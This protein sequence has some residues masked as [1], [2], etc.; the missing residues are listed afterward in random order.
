[1]TTE[2]KSSKHTQ[3]YVTLTLRVDDQEEINGAYKLR[4]LVS[5]FWWNTH[6]MEKEIQRNK[7]VFVSINE[8]DLRVRH[9][10]DEM[11]TLTLFN[12]D[13][14]ID[15]YADELK[16]QVNAT[17]EVT[18]QK[19]GFEGVIKSGSIVF[20]NF[21]GTFKDGEW[22]WLSQSKSEGAELLLGR[23]KIQLKIPEKSKL[24][25]YDFV[26]EIPM[27]EG[28]EYLWKLIHCPHENIY[29]PLEL[30]SAYEEELMGLVKT[31][32]DGKS[33]R[34]ERFPQPDMGVYKRKGERKNGEKTEYF[35]ETYLKPALKVH[36][37]Q[38]KP[39]SGN[40]GPPL[41]WV[42]QSL[43]VVEQRDDPDKKSY[44]LLDYDQ[45]EQLLTLGKT[46]NFDHNF[47]VTVQ[48]LP[49]GKRIV[50]LQD[51]EEAYNQLFLTH[52]SNPDVVHGRY[53]WQMARF[54]DVEAEHVWTRYRLEEC[55]NTNEIDENTANLS[56]QTKQL[57]G[58]IL[59]FYDFNRE[60][61]SPDD[62]WKL[63]I[64]IPE[65]TTSTPSVHPRLELSVNEER[66]ALEL[67]RPNILAMTPEMSFYSKSLL[68]SSS[69]PADRLWSEHLKG[70][71]LV[72]QNNLSKSS[73][74]L[75]KQSIQFKVNSDGIPILKPNNEQVVYFKTAPIAG[76]DRVSPSR[77]NLS[78]KA[79][80]ESSTT[81][82]I[83][84]DPNHGLLA[85]EVKELTLLFP[86]RTLLIRAQV[87]LI[88]KHSTEALM[89]WVERKFLEH[90]DEVKLYHRNLVLEHGEFEL[91][92]VYQDKE[93]LQTTYNGSH[94]FIQAVR[95]RYC[96]AADLSVKSP[97]LAN[98]LP[99]G[100]FLTN[101]K[102]ITSKLTY[103][104]EEREKLPKVGIAWEREDGK[105]LLKQNLGIDESDKNW[106][107]YLV[108]PTLVDNK[109]QLHLKEAPSNSPIDVGFYRTVNSHTPLL[110]TGDHIYDNLGVVR[111]NLE[112]EEESDWHVDVI[113]YEPLPEKMCFSISVAN[114][115]LMDHPESVESQ[116]IARD[117]T[118]VIFTCDGLKVKSNGE[119]LKPDKSRDFHESVMNLGVF[120]FYSHIIAP[121][122]TPLEGVNYWPRYRGVPFLVTEVTNFNL[123]K[124]LRPESLFFT[125]ILVNPEQIDN[126][127][128]P[129]SLPDFILHAL[130]NQKVVY[131]RYTF[132][133]DSPKLELL[134]D[135]SIDWQFSF[136]P[137]Q[138]DHPLTGK[139]ICLTGDVRLNQGKVQI[140]NFMQTGRATVDALGKTWDV[141][142]IPLNLRSHTLFSQESSGKYIQVVY[143]FLSE[144]MERSFEQVY[145]GEPTVF[146]KK[147][148][149]RLEV[150][151]VNLEEVSYVL[152]KEGTQKTY[153]I[154]RENLRHYHQTLVFDFPPGFEGTAIA[155]TCILFSTPLTLPES[156]RIIG[157][158]T[159]TREGINTLVVTNY[160]THSETVHDF[161]GSYCQIFQGDKYSTHLISDYEVLSTR[162]IKWEFDPSWGALPQD[163]ETY[164][165]KVF[166]A[167][168]LMISSMPRKR[169]GYHLPIQ[170]DLEKKL[171]RSKENISALISN[172]ARLLLYLVRQEVR[173]KRLTPNMLQG[174]S[175]CFLIQ[176][177]GR[178]EKKS[179]EECLLLW[180]ER[181][182]LAT[183]VIRNIFPQDAYMD[184][185]FADDN[186]TPCEQPFKA[187][188][189]VDYYSPGQ[190]WYR[191][192]TLSLTLK[193]ESYTLRFDD[194]DFSDLNALKPGK[195]LNKTGYFMLSTSENQ[196]QGPVVAKLLKEEE[197]K[198]IISFEGHW[199]SINK[200]RPAQGLVRRPDII[201]LYQDEDE[202]FEEKYVIRQ[203]TPQKKSLPEEKVQH[204][205][206]IKY[207]KKGLQCFIVDSSLVPINFCLEPEALTNT[208]KL[209]KNAP[210]LLHRQM[211]GTMLRIDLGDDLYKR[212]LNDLDDTEK[213][214]I[215]LAKMKGVWLI[216][217]IAVSKSEQLM[218][219][220]DN[221]FLEKTEQSTSTVQT[222]TVLIFNRPINLKDLPYFA[223]SNRTLGKAKSLK[224]KE[225][226][227]RPKEIQK[228]ALEV[229][230][231][232]IIIRRLI[233][234]SGWVSYVFVPSPFYVSENVSST[235]GV[236]KKNTREKVVNYY[237]FRSLLPVVVRRIKE[238]RNYNCYKATRGGSMDPCI[239][240][241]ATDGD[242]DQQKT[243]CCAVEREA[244][245]EYQGNMSEYYP[246]N[247]SQPTFYLYETPAFENMEP[248]WH[249]PRKGQRSTQ[250][251]IKNQTIREEKLLAAYFLPY[252]IYFRYGS[253]K[254]GALFHHEAR[255]II[256]DL[257]K[258][259]EAQCSLGKTV[260]FAIREPQ[261][262]KV[263]GC[264]SAAIENIQYED[265]HESTKFSSRR[266]K[267]RWEDIFGRINIDDL[268]SRYKLALKDSGKL[269]Y[270]PHFTR[271]ESN[272]IHRPFKVIVHHNYD[273]FALQDIEASIPAYFDEATET[274]SWAA[275]YLASRD[276]NLIPDNMP[277]RLELSDPEGASNTNP[278]G[279]Q[280]LLFHF[281]PYF[282]LT[283]IEFNEF[284][285]HSI[286]L[287]SKGDASYLQ[288]LG[289]N[290]KLFISGLQAEMED[291][292]IAPWEIKEIQGTTLYFNHVKKFHGNPDKKLAVVVDLFHLLG[293]KVTKGDFTLWPF[294]LQNFPIVYPYAKFQILWLASANRKI[295]VE[296]EIKIVQQ[297]ASCKFYSVEKQVKLLMPALTAPK[298]AG[299]LHLLP[300]E[301]GEEKT[302]KKTLFFGNGA[303]PKNGSCEIEETKQGDEKHYGVKIYALDS[304]EVEVSFPKQPLTPYLYLI[305]YLLRGQTVY[306]KW[307]K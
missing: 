251:F 223:L 113:H 296:D 260:D 74:P 142:S 94:A 141:Q 2:L 170:L 172:D 298:V 1:M 44:T 17:V 284:G 215:D 70:A 171:P 133:E 231:S 265:Q 269:E 242:G 245:Y 164:S 35:S 18:P 158:G 169:I 100:T 30:L 183:L 130:R 165:F 293:V 259:N 189:D 11:S 283:E 8:N 119:V 105:E 24:Q 241:Q 50:Q 29:S 255:N 232:G 84:R 132:S 3:Q 153:W 7:T 212:D 4:L 102:E 93:A 163:Q 45:I 80:D 247:S 275:Y 261:Q 71:S 146:P 121:S 203:A 82:A 221:A 39:G 205:V 246:L 107:D 196:V 104:P 62:R 33:I 85:W 286:E 219:M 175:Y 207:G 166:E 116:N 106:L 234:S 135:S 34:I 299:V 21:G 49:K 56:V 38:E 199:F 225:E 266:L 201:S 213:T 51:E 72:F 61:A 12:R 178:E 307:K 139:L 191:Y 43:K 198:V 274:S 58:A 187:G 117:V 137:P 55:P 235:L 5:K 229:G 145:E 186:E 86:D 270:T 156:Q 98:W 264:V 16:V 46:L 19:G 305:K 253:D 249:I 278:E 226:D 10:P 120:G 110:F 96:L 14:T 59:K 214:P 288:S 236:E 53:L 250:Q 157:E 233:G 173:T 240:S 303:N 210:Q 258:E 87:E 272:N 181:N 202:K 180:L 81:F 151:G 222:E 64:N 67:Y 36:V 149:L 27:Q 220:S 99:G 244:V 40:Y 267:M 177:L 217:P 69:M 252:K 211:F 147:R 227:P 41:V 192:T 136:S 76:I 290:V 31:I 77:N 190:D 91:G 167:P 174:S 273:V 195:S 179:G 176:G 122:D 224:D 304:E 193:K 57:N 243:C 15:H 127:R 230:A 194:Q 124:E 295:K 37:F 143:D 184:F 185:H 289:G 239:C 95:D 302:L 301:I 271:D 52:V 281:R 208:T 148:E 123:N 134:K 155:L 42:P 101:G 206:A 138:F 125:A 256:H 47:G 23:S 238:I 306:N 237:D 150:A 268:D 280:T 26:A 115:S 20:K 182:A 168:Y 126:T 13:I 97:L 292:Q 92:Q 112:I 32:T 287:K 228:Q 73:M 285:T 297:M 277:E 248:L 25:L 118:Q 78:S 188:F 197:G 140:E 9:L 131:F 48:W 263:K 108:K 294:A 83:E 89:P 262:V 152:L 68:D 114:R 209:K 66:I 218:L 109:F 159:A 282:M 129:E 204:F 162:P 276:P 65:N 144:G 154:S 6:D 88:E 22:E 103:Y 200:V 279:I 216:S 257:S 54:N 63:L 160:T 28:A 291:S 300:E 128:N 60:G 90:Q 79:S 111:E 75:A 161:Y 254:P